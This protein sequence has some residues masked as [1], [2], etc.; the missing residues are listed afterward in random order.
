MPKGTELESGGG[1]GSRL[2]AARILALQH[3]APH[4][5]TLIFAV[6]ISLARCFEGPRYTRSSEDRTQNCL[7]NRKH[8]S[9]NRESGIGGEIEAEIETQRASGQQSLIWASLRPSSPSHDATW[10]PWQSARRWRGSGRRARWW[11]RMAV[12]L[13]TALREPSAA[14]RFWSRPGEGPEG[15]QKRQ[16]GRGKRAGRGAERMKGSRADWRSAGV[17]D[18][19]PCSK[20]MCSNEDK[21]A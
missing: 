5:R 9:R 18:S 20:A 3:Q 10:K 11:A 7:G 16:L 14:S 8:G 17:G 13:E 4:C 6:R 12:L 15:L 19:L 1:S 21:Y 2:S